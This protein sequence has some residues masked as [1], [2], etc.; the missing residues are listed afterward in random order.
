MQKV[1]RLGL[2]V[3]I[4]GIPKAIENDTLTIKLFM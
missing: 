4:V 2:K 3:A 1:R